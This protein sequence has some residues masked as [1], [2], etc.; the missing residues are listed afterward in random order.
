M[1]NHDLKDGVAFFCRSVVRLNDYH[2]SHSYA[3]FSASFSIS[4]IDRIDMHHGYFSE[5]NIFNIMHEGRY[6][7]YRVTHKKLFMILETGS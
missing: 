1:I 7:K 4:L 6:N 5:I 2:A 3:F